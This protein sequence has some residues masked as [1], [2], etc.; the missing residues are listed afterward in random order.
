MGDLREAFHDRFEILTG[1]SDALAEATQRLR[2]QVYCIETGFEDVRDF[3]SGRESDIFDRYSVFGLIRSRDDKVALATVRL[4][5]GATGRRL[6]IESCCPE[7]AGRLLYSRLGG[8]SKEAVAEISRFA[9]S[10]QAMRSFLPRERSDD[11]RRLMLEVTLGLFRAVLIMSIEHHVSH[12]CAVMEPS[13]LR[14][15]SRFGIDFN[16]LGGLVDYHGWRQP[17]FGKVEDILSLAYERRRETWSLVTDAGRLAN[18]PLP[19][20]AAA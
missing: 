9:V 16:R 1:T 19:H 15:L 10:K 17:C 3:P 20:P 13:L 2:Y 14:L 5:L 12:W 11:T 18:M 8:V 4:V 6:P 7:L